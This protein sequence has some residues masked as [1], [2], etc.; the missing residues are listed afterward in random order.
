[1]K[2]GFFQALGV[3]L[4]C[5]LIG[6]FL[7]NANHVFGPI[8]K[9]SG[10]I[11]FLILFSTSAMICGLLVFYKPYR[12]FFAGKKKEAAD[13][14]VATAVWLFA[15]LLVFLLALFLKLV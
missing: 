1:M 4:Y 13:V 15:F 2:T 8:D 9:L 11:T 12:L 6:L 14:V 10:P 3:T 7:F 5:I